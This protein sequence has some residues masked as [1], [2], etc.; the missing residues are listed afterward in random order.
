MMVFIT[1][2]I[3]IFFKSQNDDEEVWTLER[4]EE[5]L[6]R[7]TV[8]VY[9]L[10]FT[11]W[12]FFNMWLR[13]RSPKDSVLHGF[14]L[15][16]TAG[17][18]AGNMWCTRVAAVFASDCASAHKCSPWGHW[19]PWTLLSGALFFAVANI[20]YMTQGTRK[21]ESLF[22]V[23]VFQGSNIVSN[24]LSSLIILREMDSAPCWKLIGYTGCIVVMM[25]CLGIPVSGE[26]VLCPSNELDDLQ[27]MLSMEEGEP[28][29]TESESE[30][31]RMD[32]VRAI[33]LDQFWPLS[34]S[35]ENAE[36]SLDEEGSRNGEQ[37]QREKSNDV[38]TAELRK[39]LHL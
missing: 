34:L 20:P 27:Q 25:V 10:I 29:S 38:P 8:L 17:S 23:T 14:S 26:E 32:F 16:A 24:S 37:E 22:M 36:D 7:W 2:A 28:D 4:A 5:I 13:K 11:M 12:F 18:M 15:G 1:A 6:L 33:S 31:D 30:P 9:G 21:Y 39:P 19:L 3:S 35:T